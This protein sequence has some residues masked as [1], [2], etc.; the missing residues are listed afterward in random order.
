MFPK[1]SFSY[2]LP[3][4]CLRL[5]GLADYT[6]PCFCIVLLFLH[7]IAEKRSQSQQEEMAAGH[8]A[9]ANPLSPAPCRLLSCWF[10]EGTQHHAAATHGCPAHIHAKQSRD[11]TQAS[12]K[13][14]YLHFDWSTDSRY[15]FLLHNSTIAS[16]KYAFFFFF[17]SCTKKPNKLKDKKCGSIYSQL[18]CLSLQSTLLYSPSLITPTLGSASPISNG[19][20]VSEEK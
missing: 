10:W 7:C 12:Y 14:V 5:A 8:F 11:E 16:A 2:E 15:R 17:N 20:I 9:T 6:R 4:Q 3:S 19:C 13:Q 1:R 18:V